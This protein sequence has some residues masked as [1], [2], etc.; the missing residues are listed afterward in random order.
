MPQELEALLRKSLD[1]VDRARKKQLAAG[2][3]FLGLFVAMAFWIGRAAS[4][5]DVRT[6]VTDSAKLVAFVVAFCT[7]AICV[8][9]ARMTQKILKAIELL[10]QK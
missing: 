9:V 5:N 6:V 8:F 2:A 4:A 1:D 3:L 10:S 7:F